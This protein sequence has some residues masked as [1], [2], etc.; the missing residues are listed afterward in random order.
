MN[1]VDTAGKTWPKVVNEFEVLAEARVSKAKPGQ[2]WLRQ[3]R[4]ES[5]GS[6]SADNPGA[7]LDL[8]W[9]ANTGEQF[10]LN[11]AAVVDGKVIVASR[12][13][14]SPYSMMLAYDA[15][16]GAEAWRTYLD[17]DAESSPTVH[18]DKVYLTTGVG[19]VYALD[20]KNGAVAWES[21]EDEHNKGETVRRYGR[22]G[23]P[24]SVF[25]LE[26]K[27]PVAVY[28]EWGQVI[29]RNAETG[30]KLPGGF[31]AP[32]GWGQ[33]RSTAVRQPGSTTAYLHSGSSQSLIRMDL[34]TCKQISSVDTAGDLFTQS[35]PAFTNPE[36]R[37]TAAGDHHGLRHPRAQPE[38]RQHQL[39]RQA[40]H[41][42][43]L[44][45]RPAAGQQP[46]DLRLEGLC[47]QHRWR[48]AGV[49]HH[50]GHPG[51]PAVGN[52]AGLPA[53]RKPDG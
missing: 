23:G 24:V 35:S 52:Q 18:G 36:D 4:D 9:S 19:R 16:T 53:G 6:D 15:R 11:G 21:I 14:D 44:P 12:A 22:A 1:A 28:Q 30:A 50:L 40:R 34:S 42:R 49:R 32:A 17:G 3:G 48:G 8:R 2:D 33:F 10:H 5:G 25:D 31:S 41:R 43:H 37:R 46:R 38:G 27:P 45:G 51:H 29:C 39:A 7:D 13:L 47:G 26:G 20:A